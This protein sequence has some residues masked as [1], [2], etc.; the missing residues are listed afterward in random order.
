MMTT[1]G[2]DFAPRCAQHDADD[3]FVAENYATLKE[4]AVFAAGVPEEL[5]GGGASHAELCAMIR[6]LAHYCTSTA[7][8]L[9]MHTHL[10][11]TLAYAW[12]SGNKT[13]EPM[14][15][16]VAAERLVLVSTGGSD[17]LPGSGKLT[18]VEGGYR[19]N[20]RKIFGSGGPG[21]DVLMT[22]GIYDDPSAGPTVYHF[23]VPLKAEGVKILDNWK[24]L[25]M[26]GTGSN[27]I[28]LRDVFV[29]DAAM[30]GVKRPAGKWHPFFHIV[31]M[32]AIPVFNAAYLGIAE[33]AR[34]I[35]LKLAAKKKHDALQIALVGE[36]EN[37]LVT[38]QLAHAS[39]VQLASTEQPGPATS[40]A[41]MVRRTIFGKA[42]LRTVE[43]ALEAAG[44][45]SFYRETGLERLFRD[46]QGV[47]FH[48]LQEK[49][50]TRFTGQVLLGLDIDS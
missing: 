8:A 36:L 6:E 7:L 19:F 31:C 20:A 32:I 34:D 45:S 12:R 14:L 11:A 47:R 16:R 25:G 1:L 17:W 40:S 27:D 39:M 46:I 42:A 3:S 29:P 33:S 49:P 18:K 5:G 48:P 10:V 13:V 50:Q 43:K 22:T 4:H 9:S 37:E 26:R 35:A 15:K 21:G 28:E 24:A 41:V 30:G 2:R 44:G 23:P 38:A